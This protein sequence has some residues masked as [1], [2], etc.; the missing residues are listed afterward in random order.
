MDVDNASSSKFGEQPADKSALRLLFHAEVLHKSDSVVALNVRSPEQQGHTPLPGQCTDGCK[1]LFFSPKFRKVLLLE[2]F[3]LRPVV[4]EPL[5]QLIRG[6]ALSK[7]LIDYGTLLRHA[8][9][10][11]PVDENA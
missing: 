3:P 8:A 5:T 7:P 1:Q 6:G 9:G 11:Q 2:L 4:P 10:P